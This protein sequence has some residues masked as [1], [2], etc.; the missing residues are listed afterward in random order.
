MPIDLPSLARQKGKR[1]D[2]TLRPINP[3][4]AQAQSLA[5]ILVQVTD[6]WKA[7]IPRILASYDPSP[8]ADALMTDS[9]SDM[10][11][12]IDATETEVSRLVVFLT[13]RL[14]DWA[15]QIEKWHR[16]KWA[17]AALTAT[18]VDLSTVLTAGPVQETLGAWLD[19][20]VALVKDV[21]AQTQG[22]I[23]DSVFRGYQQRLPIRDVAREMNEATGLGRKRA[24]RIASDQTSKISAALDEERMAEA[25]IEWF[26]WRHSGKLHPRPEHKARD[27]KIYD[28]KTGKERDGDGSVSADD[29][30]GMKPYCG[31]RAQAWLP[32]MDEFGL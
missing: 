26:K 24:I 3:T 19:R 5:A 17:G 8:L 16:G 30:P 9:T 2:I 10:R 21:S 13:A 7:A 25:G 14:R 23:A 12:A 31:C 29:R 4:Q 32:M 15:V 27:G 11:Q 28:L 1:R 22:R 18:G 20:N 6:A